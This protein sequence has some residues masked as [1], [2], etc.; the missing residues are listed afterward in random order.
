MEEKRKV[1]KK[2]KPISEKPKKEKKVEVKAGGTLKKSLDA[3]SK[4]P[5]FKTASKI[6]NAN[7]SFN[8]QKLLGNSDP[9]DKEKEDKARHDLD[10]Y[11]MLGLNDNEVQDAYAEKEALIH[12]NKTKEKYGDSFYNLDV[13]EKVAFEYRLGLAKTS[14]YKRKISANAA[15]SISSFCKKQGIDIHSYERKDFFILAPLEHFRE[16]N[17]TK[18][19]DPLILYKAKHGYFIPVYDPD[20]SYTFLR[21]LIATPMRD[22]KSF[23]LSYCFLG[24]LVGTVISISLWGIGWGVLIL[25]TLCGIGFSIGFTGSKTKNRRLT[26]NVWNDVEEY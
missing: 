19:K 4:S 21:Y 24:I 5:T 22:F 18:K 6:F 3:N 26:N 13:L 11:Q 14:M 7:G 2:R 15:A 16:S 1:I 8:A 9:A 17:T 20:E 10:V 23:L 25:P 12:Y